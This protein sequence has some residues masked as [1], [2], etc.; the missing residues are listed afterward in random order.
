[1]NKEAKIT[2]AVFSSAILN[3]KKI[4]TEYKDQI[5]NLLKDFDPAEYE[6]SIG[7]LK[8]KL[9]IEF[10]KELGYEVKVI[11]QHPKSLHN[12]NKKIIKDNALSIFFIHHNSSIMIKLLSF[13]QTLEGKKVVPVHLVEIKH[14]NATYLFN[15]PTGKFHH[16]E[17]RWSAIAQL[18]YIWMGR[19]KK[20]LTTYTSTY[21]S[22]KTKK[23][24]QK[25]GQL[26]FD[27]WN[28]HNT[29]VEGRLNNKLFSVDGWS[30]DYDNISPDIV[31][32]DNEKSKVI[33]IEVKTIGSSVKSNLK[34]YQRVVNTLRDSNKWSC[35]LYYL[36]S[37]GH[38]KNSDWK[39]LK[40]A[41][42]QI[43]LW[44]ELFDKI[45][46][47]DIAPYIDVD[48]EQY[49]LMPEWI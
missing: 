12:S 17:S 40:E 9:L 21:S 46:D 5:R 2:V 47:S 24:L 33:M 45:K 31:H 32:I 20:E 25:K 38:E 16:S 44:E 22:T 8:N 10:I 3:E 30:K 14:K 35:E 48:L 36:L 43:L 19:E 37:Y 28:S 1:M 29:I 15:Q 26:S 13:A 7:K 11:S 4:F 39:L 41:K 34:L 42:A 27:R 23:W 6:I 18:A 49:T